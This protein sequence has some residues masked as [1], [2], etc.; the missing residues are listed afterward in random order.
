[1]NQEH[2]TLNSQTREVA[3]KTAWMWSFCLAAAV[4][5]TGCAKF[6]MRKNIPWGEGFDGRIEQPMRVEAVWVD[7][8][9]TKGDQKPI[10]GFGG[11]LYFFGPNNS[12]DSV[13]VDGTLVIYGF[14]ETSRDPTNVI[15]DRKIVYPAKE[16]ETLYSKSKLGHSYS[17][18]VPW[19]EAGGVKKEITLLVRFIPK[20]GAVIASEQIRVLLPGTNAPLV[21]VKSV[22]SSQSA[23]PTLYRADASGATA[24]GAVQQASYQQPDAPGAP[25]VNAPAVNAPAVNAPADHTAGISS[26]TIPLRGDQA[27]H[28]IQR[29]TYSGGAVVGTMELPDPS[30]PTA[31]PAQSRPAQSLPGQSPPGQSA[32]AGLVA[33]QISSASAIP[34]TSPAERRSQEPASPSQPTSA[35]V[36]PSPS[37]PP[38]P[39]SSLLRRSTHF[40]HVK[41]PVQA[42]R[43]AQQSFGRG[44][45]GQ[46]PAEP[47]S[48][49][50]SSPSPETSHRPPGY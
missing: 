6:D 31:L 46:L 28:F 23:A 32:P 40:E 43:A 14:D 50:A 1:L 41:H 7:T 8:V 10:R 4:T 35:A 17:V 33:A 47:R 45:W 5:M 34:T 36:S 26:Y 29:P 42:A 18:W 38:V 11:R 48:G 9:L 27:R 39:L 25:A 37:T 22:N 49:P 30:K 3:V 2:G 21:D 19:D 15:P 20:E 44:P 24:S 16:F 13:K 12:Q